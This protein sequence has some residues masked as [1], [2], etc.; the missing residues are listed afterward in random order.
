VLRRGFQ[1]K[2]VFVAYGFD[3]HWRIAV[4]LV[5]YGS[6]RK[7]VNQLRLNYPDMRTVSI[8]TVR[9]FDLSA[10]GKE[11]VGKARLAMR[12]AVDSLAKEGGALRIQSGGKEGSA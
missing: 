2:A 10:E 8:S 6:R 9:R 1:G 12:D 3:H 7:A 5:R 4:A 11:L